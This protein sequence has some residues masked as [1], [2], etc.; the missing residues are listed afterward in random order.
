MVHDDS[1][2]PWLEDIHV[3]RQRMI[4]KVDSG[5]DVSIKSRREFGKLD[6][7][8]EL[9]HVACRLKGVSADIR[10]QKSPR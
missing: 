3:N 7:T 5:A 9:T 1:V 6:P 10:H 4:F 8:P 2:P